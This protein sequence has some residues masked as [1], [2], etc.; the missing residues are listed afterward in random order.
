VTLTYTNSAGQQV[1]AQRNVTWGYYVAAV[2]AAGTRVGF[3]HLFLRGS[4]GVNLVSIPFYPA[5]AEPSAVFGLPPDRLL[6]A[7]YVQGA[8]GGGR[9]RL[10][11]Q[12]AELEPGRG[13][14]LKLDADVT[15]STLGVAVSR[16][17][18]FVIEL[19]PGWNLIGDPFEQEVLVSDLRFAREGEGPISLAEA[20]DKGWVGPSVYQYTQAAGYSTVDRLQPWR[21]YWILVTVEGGVRMLVSAP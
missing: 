3:Q 12:V 6:L 16:A 19:P 5:Q 13:Y 7:E 1:K 4:N 11:P 8:E 20:V 18:A 10:Y 2:P 9:Y 14:F 15:L 21:G 17:Q